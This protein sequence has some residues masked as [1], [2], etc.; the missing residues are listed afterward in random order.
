MVG[1][2]CATIPLWPRPQY[3]SVRSVKSVQSVFWLRG[4]LG[5]W[6]CYVS[7]INVPYW[8]QIEDYYVRVGS[9]LRGFCESNFPDLQPAIA[10]HFWA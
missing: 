8:R 6:L 2:M 10:E 3:R 4:I 5:V 9:H 7:P 1:M